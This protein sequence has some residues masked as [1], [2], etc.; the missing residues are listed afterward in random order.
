MGDNNNEKKNIYLIIS[1]TPTKFAKCIRKIGRQKYN[2]VAIA[3]DDD[4]RRV[5]AFARVKH[6]A[7][8]VAG[9]VRESVDRYTLKSNREVPI[10]AFRIS[11]TKE[12]H[13]Q[14]CEKL[15]TV[16]E[17]PEY[18]YNL[19]AV[20]THPLFK[21][22][23]LYKAFTCVEFASYIMRDYGYLDKKPACKYTPDDLLV[24]LKDNIVYEG[25]VR[26][27]MSDEYEG[28]EYFA[29]FTWDNMIKSVTNVCRLI[30]RVCYNKGV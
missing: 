25:D 2:H 8:L 14:I 28:A 4:F 11:V 17:D 5:Y 27:I 20:L 13:K 15:T 12:E 6:K 9:L 23:G 21:G 7:V 1:K 22:F 18:M 19:F 16:L 24:E 26:K 29:P 10:V 30:G 3:L